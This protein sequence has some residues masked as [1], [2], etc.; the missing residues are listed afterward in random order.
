MVKDPEKKEP[1]PPLVKEGK[2]PN[3][4]QAPLVAECEPEPTPD[5]K[6]V[7]AALLKKIGEILAQYGGLESDVPINHEYW[8]LV[9]QYRGL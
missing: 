4:S 5:P 6:E 8:N 2:E 9:N 7:K 3:A 1:E